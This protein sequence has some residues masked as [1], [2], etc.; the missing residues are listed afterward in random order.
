MTRQDRITREIQ[1]HDRDL[2][3]RKDPR[4][5][6]QILRKN[7]ITRSVWVDDKTVITYPVSAPSFI[8]ALTDTWTAMG[9]PV[10]W[11]LE[12]IMRK[13][14]AIDDWQNPESENNKMLAQNEKVDQSHD[15]DRYNKMEAFCYDWRSQFKKA[16]SDINTSN[17][18]KIEK[19]G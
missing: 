4:G 17:L 14:R 19:R 10:E 18:A 11:G 16:T 8:V 2:F 15:R 3:C 12:P 13:L 7:T 6:L 5:V 1:K 9:K